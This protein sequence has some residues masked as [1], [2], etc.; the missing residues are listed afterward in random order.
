MQPQEKTI[1]R[2]VAGRDRPN[3]SRS[4]PDQV[5]FLSSKVNCC[6]LIR[7]KIVPRTGEEMG[8]AIGLHPFVYLW[9]FLMP[10]EFGVDLRRKIWC[11]WCY[12]LYKTCWTWNFL[13]RK[14]V[15]SKILLTRGPALWL[16]SSTWIWPF[17]YHVYNFVTSLL[18]VELCW[19]SRNSSPA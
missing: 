8:K 19:M 5:G 6:R 15:H 12:Q 1:N 16:P 10:W 14:V 2:F 9:S 7:P 17:A 3:H 4:V 11:Q 13:E 18:F